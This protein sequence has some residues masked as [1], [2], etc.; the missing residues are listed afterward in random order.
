MEKTFVITIARGFGTGGKEIATKVAKKFGIHCYE[1]RILTLASEMSGIDELE[2]SNSNE[3]MPPQPSGLSFFLQKLPRSNSYIARNEKFVA[4]D[5]LFQAQQEIIT[6]LS[7]NESC[8]I[9]GKCADDILRYKQNVIS[10]YIEAPRE[11][12]L[13][14]TMDSMKTSREVANNTIEQTDKFRT[15]YYKYYTNGKDWTSVINYD[16]TLNSEKIGIDECVDLIVAYALKKFS[17]LDIEV[18]E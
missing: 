17:H 15:E 9:V 16:M 13:K 7:K 1:N 8:V 5:K 3:K 6:R 10:L 18:K 2:F 12:C 14:R 4:N 11:F